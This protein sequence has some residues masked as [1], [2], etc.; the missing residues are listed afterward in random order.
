MNELLQIWQG[1]TPSAKQQLANQLDTSTA[2]LSQLAH[3]HR[4]P[5]KHFERSLAL[6]LT[7]LKKSAA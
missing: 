2:Y 1:L 5:G 6:E 3:G 7:K 4:N